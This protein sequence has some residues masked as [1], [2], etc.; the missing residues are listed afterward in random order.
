MNKTTEKTVCD[1]LEAA[2]GAGHRSSAT[3]VAQL[4]GND[5]R[6]FLAEDGKDI[7]TICREA[8]TV[9][10]TYADGTTCY[11]FLDDSSMV[12]TPERWEVRKAGQPGEIKLGTVID[13]Q[14]LAPR[15]ILG[16]KITPWQSEEK[17][18]S[19]LPRSFGVTISF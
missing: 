12:V 14:I 11:G 19:G 4:L 5:S 16:R 1:V 6:N 18:E 2:I 7:H 13:M 9:C 3:A 10:L 8:A 17:L 15:E